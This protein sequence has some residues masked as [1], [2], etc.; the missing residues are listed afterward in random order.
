MIALDGYGLEPGCKADL[1]LLEGENFSRGCRESTQAEARREG[2]T[3][4]GSR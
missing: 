1:V 3:D 2:W 4:R